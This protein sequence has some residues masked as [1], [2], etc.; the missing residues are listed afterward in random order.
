MTNVLIVDDERI[1]Q[2]LFTYYIEKT[3]GKYTLAGAIKD[4]ANA[5]IYCESGKVDLIIMDVC[6]V[7]EHSGIAAAKEIKSKYPDIK[8]IIV[9]SAP[10]YRFIE[11]AREAGADSFW[12]K[13]F[14]DEELIDVMDK[15]M[16]GENVYPDSTPDVQIGNIS[17]D[18]FTPKELEV[19]SY[20]VQNMGLHEIADKM[21]VAYTTVRSHVKNLKEKT[22]ENNL[23]GLCYLV[24]KNRLI[25]PEY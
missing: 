13:E 9:T 18:M 1:V 22:G 2:E 17:S 21:G 4:A 23:I 3:D 25:L 7:N 14:G 16:N 15:T 20:L 8:I 24:T 10:D 19:L 6:T 5:E 12:Y 11:K